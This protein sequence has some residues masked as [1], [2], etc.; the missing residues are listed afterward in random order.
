MVKRTLPIGIQSFRNIRD[1][2]CYYVDKTGYAARLYQEGTHYF[3]SRPRRFGKSLFVN[4]LKH[5][6]Q[7]DRDL[8]T[9]L[10]AYSTWDW[11]VRYPVVKLSFESGNFKDPDSL[12]TRVQE[13][14]LD[15]EIECGV[16]ARHQSAAGVYS[17]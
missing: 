7:G 1:R 3:L 6:F 12:H 10:Q 8:F 4:T 16:E 17:I 13:Q 2:D 11:S 14:L 15:L 9:G 5:L